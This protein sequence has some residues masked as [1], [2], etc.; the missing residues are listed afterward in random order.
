MIDLGEINPH[1][2]VLV[3]GIPEAAFVRKLSARLTDGL[4]VAIGAEAEVRKARSVCADCDNVMFIPA[5]P[6]GVIPWQDRFF[7]VVIARSDSLQK[8]T[9]RV[10]VP[11]GRVLK[12]SL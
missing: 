1:D 10:L 8:E 6:S 7:T 3:L 9:S 2:R 5:D 11:N 4:L 12:L